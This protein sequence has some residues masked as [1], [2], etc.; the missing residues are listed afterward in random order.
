MTMRIYYCDSFE[1]PLPEGHSFPMAK[2]R[3][4][5]E[6]VQAQLASLNAELCLPPAISDQDVLAVHCANYVERVRSG[7]LSATELRKIGF[8]YSAQM[9]ERTRRVS[10]A[11]LQAL[12]DA[13][14][15]AG[16]GVNLAG[17]THHAHY[18][19]GAGYCVFNDAVIAA[20]GVQ[21]RALAK[22]V[23]IVDLDV[24]QGNGTASLC[25]HDP[26]ITTFSM[27][28]AKNY[29]AIKALSDID[30]ELR[31]GTTDDTYLALLRLHL[32]RAF[33]LARPDAVV[34]LAGAD[35]FERDRLGYLK[36]TQAGLAERD[37]IVFQ[38]C[39]SRGVAVALVMAGGYA[40]NIADIVDIHFQSVQRAAEFARLYQGASKRH[41]LDTATTNSQIH[42]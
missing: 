40:P 12:I 41:S 34:Y 20:R 23:L 3:L 35:P 2:Y 28:A 18:D 33:D 13:L 30:V 19:F 10:G 31:N 39:L 29:P 1:L 25:A 27:H 5:R 17:G 32:P 36:L 24:H 4:L 14:H 21:A 8:P 42:S 7:T 16:V 15:G 6:R 9:A 37:R 22:R 26:S 11:S 38:A